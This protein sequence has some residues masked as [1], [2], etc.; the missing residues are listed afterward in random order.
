MEGVL[1][2]MQG[3]ALLEIFSSNSSL[4]L[5]NGTIF[6]LRP[7]PFNFT[8]FLKKSHGACFRKVGGSDFPFPLGYAIGTRGAVDGSGFCQNEESFGGML[9]VKYELGSTNH[10]CTTFLCTYIMHQLHISF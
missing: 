2:A 8:T 9:K 1:E 3:N 5:A 6:Y 7:P 10:L 4:T